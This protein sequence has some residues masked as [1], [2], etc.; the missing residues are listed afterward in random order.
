MTDRKHLP[1]NAG[2]FVVPRWI[3][4]IVIAMSLATFSGLFYI[5]WYMSSLDGRVATLETDVARSQ[6]AAVRLAADRDRLTIVEQQVISIRQAQEAQ[7]RTLE[8]ISDRLEQFYRNGQPPAP[9]Q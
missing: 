7:T 8:R 2:Y 5:G 6:S 9:R 3:A 4:Q 1:E